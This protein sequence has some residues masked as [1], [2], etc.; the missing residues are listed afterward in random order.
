MSNICLTSLEFLVCR[1]RMLSRPYAFG[2]VLCI[3]TSPEFK[4]AC[5]VSSHSLQCYVVDALRRSLCGGLW[6]QYGHYFLDPQYE[7]V[8]HIICS[9][10]YAT[11]AFDFEFS[12][13][14]SF[15]RFD[16]ISDYIMRLTYNPLWKV[17]LFYS[18]LLHH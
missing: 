18:N 9:D 3:L 5:G 8:Q 2:C 10:E 7:S 12:N 17:I 6:V 4:S 1:Y 11:Y 13:S 14:T 16:H 15:T